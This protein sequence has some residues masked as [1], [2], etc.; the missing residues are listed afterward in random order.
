M[1]VV[2]KAVTSNLIKATVL[3]AEESHRN[4]VAV[5]THFAYACSS[6][7]VHGKES[8]VATKHVTP[9]TL[10]TITKTY[11]TTVT[12]STAKQNTVTNK[13]KL[14]YT[15]PNR[16]VQ[17]IQ[18]NTSTL[19]TNTYKCRSSLSVEYSTNATVL[20]LKIVNDRIDFAIASTLPSST[21]TTSSFIDIAQKNI[22]ELSSI[23][24]SP[25]NIRN[26]N[27]NNIA[28]NVTQRKDV[29]SPLLHNNISKHISTLLHKY[30][31]CS[32]LVDWPTVQNRGWCS[33]DCGRILY[34]LDHL[35]L[36]KS[37]PPI[38]LFASHQKQQQ[39]CFDDEWGR[40]PM[41]CI[42][43]HQEQQMDSNTSTPTG[44]SST[45]ATLPN[46]VIN[47]WNQFCQQYLPD[48]YY[49]STLQNNQQHQLNNITTVVNT[50]QIEYYEAT[51]RNS[52]RSKNLLLFKHPNTINT[53]YNSSSYRDNDNTSL[54]SS[55]N[56]NKNSSGIR[57]NENPQGSASVEWNQQSF[58]YF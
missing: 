4:A 55:L 1:F 36:P 54:M 32:I 11:P 56:S 40:N 2:S 39:S 52:Q 58:D 27:N 5:G 47:V 37:I 42:Q 13:S 14:I 8:T 26:K 38:C 23:P 48:C 21:K 51:V 19:P 49:Q 9:V 24:F 25:H 3:V 28:T 41:Y 10:A 20:I 17:A 12:T 22:I 46:G 57:G 53:S 30:N 35:T 50:T 44:T 29:Q 7:L 34:L 43:S 31:V 15:T 6:T 45:D 16:I 33:K 18:W